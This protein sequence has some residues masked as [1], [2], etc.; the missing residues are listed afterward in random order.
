MVLVP[1]QR[2][3][4]MEQN[5]VLRNNTTHLQHLIF[6]KPEKNKKWGKDSLFNKWYWENWLAIS[7]KL[8]LDP[9]LTPY[10]KINS[11][12]IRDLNVRPNT[13]KTLEENLGNTFQDI[14]MGKDF[15][16]ETPKAMATKAKID[17]WDLIKLKSFCTAKET[18]IRM[19]RQLTEWEK[20]FAIYSSDKGLI[21]RTYK[22]LKQIYKKK[23]NNPIK[24][25]AKD[26]NRHFSNEDMHTANRHMKKCLS[27]LAIRNANQNHNEIPS[28]TS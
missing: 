27:S 3:R 23:T 5:R 4:P 7:R 22:E 2:Y 18:T 6:D 20:I 16:S 17:K 1:K 11:R 8:K 26:M 15:M 9:F 21:S 25:W 10:T 14:G 12:W 24:K 13:V 28:H 19:N